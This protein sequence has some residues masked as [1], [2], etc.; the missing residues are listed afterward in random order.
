MR[1]RAQISSY[2]Q[3]GPV[4]LLRA[5]A[6]Q[7]CLDAQDMTHANEHNTASAC[8]SR[9]KMSIIMQSLEIYARGKAARF[10]AKSCA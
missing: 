1:G 7:P 3:K 2:G 5:P 8:L 9:L 6:P 4:S 10:A